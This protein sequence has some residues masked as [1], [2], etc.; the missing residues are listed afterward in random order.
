MGEEHVEDGE[1]ND[2]LICTDSNTVQ[3][4]VNHPR[5]SAMEEA[6]PDGGAHADDCGCN[7]DRTSANFHRR[8][9]PEDIAEA[10]QQIVQSASAVHIGETHACFFRN[11]CPG[12]T[13]LHLC[14]SSGTK[15][16]GQVLTVFSPYENAHA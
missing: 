10:E 5:S 4:V 13:E 15:G 8:R 12:G 6:Q 9:D 3:Y 2:S 1:L 16:Y 7:E 14:Q 11:G